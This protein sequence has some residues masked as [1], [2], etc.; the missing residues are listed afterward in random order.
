MYAITS[1]NYQT[2]MQCASALKTCNTKIPRTALMYAGLF[3]AEVHL[4]HGTPA[5]VLQTM[6]FKAKEEVKYLSRAHRSVYMESEEFVYRYGIYQPI[7]MQD[8]PQ[9]SAPIP[10]GE[11]RINLKDAGI[12]PS[13]INVQV[14][15]DLLQLQENYFKKEK[16]GLKLHGPSLELVS[17]SN[18]EDLYPVHGE[19]SVLK[20][21]LN[22]LATSRR[23]LAKLSE[24]SSEMC[25]NKRMLQIVNAIRCNEL[26]T[27]TSLLGG[28]MHQGVV[29]IVLSPRDKQE[30]SGL[31]LTAAASVGVWALFSLDYSHV[32]PIL[33]KCQ[34]EQL[35]VKLFDYVKGI[36]GIHHESDK[37][38]VNP[39]AAK[40]Q[41][42]V[43][44]MT[45]T[46]TCNTQHVS[47]SL[48]RQL[49]ELC[50]E[51][52]I[53][54]ETPLSTITGKWSTLFKGYTLSL[55]HHCS[56]FLIARWLKWALMIHN[57]REELA[58]YTAV[59]V[60]GLVNSGKS[61]LVNTL[62]GI[63]V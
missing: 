29:D 9:F 63:D 24:K 57:L 59:G 6:E 27:C 50:R 12:K 20:S 23:E 16:F 31:F 26:D 21:P 38:E 51:R 47:Y 7:S 53:N 49:D 33:A 41:F 40:L 3:D 54:A 10:L 35:L 22:I 8:S 25:S 44:G 46:V 14:A 32:Q 5:H 61:K 52:N 34:G 30:D 11:V 19:S 37:N 42:I 48:E 15:D 2:A 13:T 55:V 43:Q 62:F 36:T 17:M 4:R 39:Y 58:K 28:F 56:R 60:V 45:K 18:I 1:G